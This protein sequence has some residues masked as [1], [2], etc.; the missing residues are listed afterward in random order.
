VKSYLGWDGFVVRA[1]VRRASLDKL[2]ARARFSSAL[3]RITLAGIALPGIA[4]ATTTRIPIDPVEA[5][6]TRRKLLSTY[7]GVV[8]EHSLMIRARSSR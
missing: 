3:A 6:S 1:R 7:L 5:S 8:R 4:L 2:L